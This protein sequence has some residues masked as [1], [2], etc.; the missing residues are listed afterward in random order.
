MLV[1]GSSTYPVS[2]VSMMCDD[3]KYD[4]CSVLYADS[5]VNETT[6]CTAVGYII[7][8]VL[9]GPLGMILHDISSRALMTCSLLHAVLRGTT[10]ISSL[11]RNITLQ[12]RVFNLLLHCMCKCLSFYTPSPY[13]V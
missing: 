4:T 12:Y 9:I 1:H 3:L 10:H 8:M 6:D 2:I 11:L 13:M 5:A 7:A